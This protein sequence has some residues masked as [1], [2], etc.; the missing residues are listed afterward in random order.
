[1]QC[2]HFHSQYSL[3]SHE[4]AFSSLFNAVLK[5]SYFP[6]TAKRDYNYYISDDYYEN[7]KY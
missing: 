5:K 6:S 2:C 1:M 7:K 3:F 4:S